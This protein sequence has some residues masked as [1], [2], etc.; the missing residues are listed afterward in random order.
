MTNTLQAVSDQISTIH[1]LLNGLP[2]GKNT[3]AVQAIQQQLSE[4][5]SHIQSVQLQQ[6]SGGHADQDRE[7]LAGCR[8]QI[9]KT[10]QQLDLLMTES[11]DDYR[12]A[13]GDLKNEFEQQSDGVQQNSNAEA[14]QLKS[15]FWQLKD[16]KEQMRHLASSMLDAEGQIEHGQLVQGGLAASVNPD[17]GE[18]G[19]PSDS[20]SLSP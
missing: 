11:A 5:G 2:L 8:V 15:I 12:E 17:T 14:Y 20:S 13:I 4:L 9:A 10:I 7:L 1:G 3:L 19:A 18:L 6:G 16:C